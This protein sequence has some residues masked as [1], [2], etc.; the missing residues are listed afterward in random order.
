MNA[1]F[2]DCYLLNEWINTNKNLNNDNLKNFLEQRIIDT[3][4]MQDLSMRNHVEMRD[5]TADPKFL[6]QKRIEKG[7]QWKSN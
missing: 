1:G 3:K 6:L 2:E 4:A 5:K 7:L